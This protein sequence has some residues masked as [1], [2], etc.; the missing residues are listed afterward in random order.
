[1][2]K[3]A[4]H[5]HT[6]VQLLREMEANYKE[7]LAAEVAQVE[8]KLASAAQQAAA[9]GARAKEG[10]EAMA[11]MPS[12]GM[13]CVQQVVIEIRVVHSPKSERSGPQD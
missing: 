12:T 13:L 7:R 9:A 10:G 8:C 2:N 11:G 3:L 4:P 6:G 1:M 5:P